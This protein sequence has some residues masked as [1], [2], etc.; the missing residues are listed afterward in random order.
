MKG[1]SFEPPRKQLRNTSSR[2]SRQA[3]DVLLF[4]AATGGQT[5]CGSGLFCS[6]AALDRRAAGAG[7]ELHLQSDRWKTTQLLRG[8]NYIDTDEPQKIELTAVL[9]LHDDQDAAS[10]APTPEEQREV[11]FAPSVVSATEN[12]IVTSIADL[13]GDYENTVR[14]LKL[15]NLVDD[16]LDWAAGNQTFVQTGDIVDRGNHAREIYDLLFKL[17][18]QAALAGGKVILLIGN[19]EQMRLEGD[20]RY[21]GPEETSWVEDLEFHDLLPEKMEDGNLYDGDVHNSHS[22]FVSLR[23]TTTPSTPTEI[24]SEAWGSGTAR[25][26]KKYNTPGWIHTEINK[27]FQ[28]MAVVGNSLYL[29]AS[30][31]PS[32]L[33]GLKGFAAG[34]LASTE[35]GEVRFGNYSGVFTPHQKRALL[36]ELLFDWHRANVFDAIQS[37]EQQS[38]SGRLSESEWTAQ[39]DFFCGD[40]SVFWD[41]DYDAECGAIEDILSFFHVKRII[42]GHTAQEDGRITTT[43]KGRKIL[44]D[45]A[46]SEAYREDYPEGRVSALQVVVDAKTG[47]EQVKALYLDEKEQGVKVEVLPT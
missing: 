27:R 29:H 26:G 4:L 32:Q 5:K 31:H 23:T 17:Q 35:E 10:A 33:E 13:H 40:D 43:C 3:K 18:D 30:M 7:P 19:H 12:S 22:E 47:L 9:H 44:A 38:P 8:E 36:L 39:Y 6:C 41:R 28:T 37:P 20:D 2:W 15:A 34:F 42:S 21:V 1:G 46:I 16:N 11:L 25:N 14:A 45:T 24:A